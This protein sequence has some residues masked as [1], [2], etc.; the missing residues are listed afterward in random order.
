MFSILNV[1]ISIVCIVFFSKMIQNY[2]YSQFH[3]TSDHILFEPEDLIIPN[4]P[5]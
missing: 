5:H 3:L 2:S 4:M 1:I